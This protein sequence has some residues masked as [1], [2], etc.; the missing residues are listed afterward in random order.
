MEIAAKAQC[1]FGEV[2]IPHQRRECEDHRRRHAVHG[3]GRRGEH[4]ELVG[5][6]VAV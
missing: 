5:E 3:A 1:V 4:A 6:A 2:Q